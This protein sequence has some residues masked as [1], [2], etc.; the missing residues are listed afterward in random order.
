MKDYKTENIVN[1]ALSGHAASGKT[2]LAESLLLVAKSINKKG[3]IQSGST[4]SDYRKQ[5]IDHQH[6]IS[7]SVLNCEF[8][9][10][11]INII[12]TPGYMDFVGEVKAALKVVDTSAIVINASEGIEALTE[13]SWEYSKEYK[14]A[15]CFIIDS[16]TIQ[17]K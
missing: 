6:S 8:L 17:S 12:D 9:D 1:L 15:K 5:E 11:K 16:S 14:N 13:L 4:L 3:N 7:M 10:K 2:C